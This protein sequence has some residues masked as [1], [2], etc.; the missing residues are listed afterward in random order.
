MHLR[1]KAK[2]KTKRFGAWFV[3]ILSFAGF[4]TPSHVWAYGFPVFQSSIFY[5]VDMEFGNDQAMNIGGLV[6]GNQDIYFAPSAPLVFS[7]DVAMAGQYFLNQSALDPTDRSTANGGITF[8]EQ[9]LTNVCQLSP[10]VGFF[11]FGSGHP[12]TANYAMLASSAGSSNEPV[13]FFCLA[14][15]IIIISNKTVTATSGYGIDNQATIIP[16][17][18]L[19][20]FIKLGETFYNGRESKTINAVNVDIGKLRTWSATNNTLR[21]AL[22]GRDLKSVYIADLSVEANRETGIV[23]TNGSALPPLGLS[24]ATPNPAYIVGSWN[25]STNGNPSAIYADAITVLSGAWKN[26]HSADKFLS[27]QQRRTLDNLMTA[28]NRNPRLRALAQARSEQLRASLGFRLATSTTINAALFSGIV[29]SNGTN[30]SGGVENFIRLLED[31]TDETLTF[32]GAIACMF[33]SQVAQGPWM[34]YSNVYKEP[35]LNWS[36]K[37]YFDW[38]K[39]PPM[40]PILAGCNDYN[41]YPMITR[42]PTNM[43]VAY[44]STVKITVPIF[45]SGYPA[46]Y[47]WYHYGDLISSGPDSTLTINNFTATNAGNYQVIVSYGDAAAPSRGFTIKPPSP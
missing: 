20:K 4:A 35:N 1:A 47:D 29:P 43:M 10:P 26:N 42:Q 2:H 46:N 25:T 27:A 15:L 24:I 37:N 41:L 44:G 14:D 38:T 21:A 32:N 45:D 18:D 7:N 19:G 28:M 13:H 22:G 36:C 3:L 6:F 9:H 11:T 31:W 34:T 5:Q 8:L 30:Y 23:L 33:Y 12:A 17:A 39:L 40:T 16:P